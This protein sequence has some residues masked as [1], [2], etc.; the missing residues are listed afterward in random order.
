MHSAIQLVQ[1]TLDRLARQLFVQQLLQQ[2][3]FK[4]V[5]THALEVAFE[6]LPITMPSIWPMK[7][8]HAGS[9][10]RRIGPAVMVNP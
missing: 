3:R 10:L 6:A 7:D 1:H 9:S 2:P 5:S 8:S 4:H